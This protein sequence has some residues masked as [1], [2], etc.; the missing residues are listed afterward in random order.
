MKKLLSF[1]IFIQALFGSDINLEIKNLKNIN[2]KLYIGLYT[3][4]DDFAVIDKAYKGYIV[5][6]NSQTV[7]YKIANI[8]DGKYAIA[9]FCDENSNGK[10]DKN[11]FGVPIESYGFSNNPKVLFNSPTYSEAE[12]VLKDEINLII[13]VK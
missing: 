9:I 8:S 1:F 4:K 13:E 6:V 5:D 12:F 10:F 7:A 3:S 2:K 11:L